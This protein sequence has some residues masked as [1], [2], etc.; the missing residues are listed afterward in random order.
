MVSGKKLAK[1]RRYSIFAIFVFA[2]LVV[3]GNDPI[4][5]SALALALSLLYEVAV[6]VSKLHDRR[7]AKVALERARTSP[8]T[9]ARCPTTRPHRCREP[10]GPAGRLDRSGA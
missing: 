6:Q 10:V 8:S 4:T 7:K 1:W 5:M 3:P 9:T 2:A